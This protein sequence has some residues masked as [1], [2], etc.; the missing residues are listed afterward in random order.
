MAIFRGKNGKFVKGPSQLRPGKHPKT[1]KAERESGR[2]RE[3]SP[4]SVIANP[5]LIAE[6]A[7]LEGPRRR[8]DGQGNHDVPAPFSGSIGI[9]TQP[10]AMEVD[11][12][13]VPRLLFLVFC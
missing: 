9:R 13:I 7:L 11:E 1:Q 12:Y 3:Q 4:L 2:R 5:D 8:E 10:L 6:E